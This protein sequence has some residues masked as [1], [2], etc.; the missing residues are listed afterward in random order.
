MSDLGICPVIGCGQ[1]LHV[2]EEDEELLRVSLVLPGLMTE[3]TLY[4]CGGMDRT[5]H[6]FAWFKTPII[7][8][9]E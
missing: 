3:G 8:E 7:L 5:G 1:L 9:E 2:M 4:S 6:V